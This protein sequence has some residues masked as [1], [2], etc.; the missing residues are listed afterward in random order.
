MLRNEVRKL[1]AKG[2]KIIIGLSHLGFSL[3]LKVAEEVEGIDV[4]VGGHGGTFLN[5]GEG[6]LKLILHFF[7]VQL[8]K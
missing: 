6:L 4:I 1:Q 3:D 8:P 5:T 7:I 2:V